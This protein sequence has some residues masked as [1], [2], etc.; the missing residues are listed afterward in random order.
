M[1]AS[2]LIINGKRYTK[3]SGP[4][5]F[6]VM[7]P[8]LDEY[9]SWNM[10]NI[11]LP[12]FMFLGDY[13][14]S[15]DTMCDTDSNTI[16]IT[17]QDWYSLLDSFSTDQRR[18]QYYIE[19]YLGKPRVDTFKTQPIRWVT[20]NFFECI[21]NRNT[22]PTTNIEWKSSEIRYQASD[23]CIECSLNFILINTYM[24]LK[25]KCNDIQQYITDIKSAISDT[26]IEIINSVLDGDWNSFLDKLFE[27]NRLNSILCEAVSKNAELNDLEWWKNQIKT[28][29]ELEV[30]EY[31][32]LSKTISLHYQGCKKTINF[33]KKII[34]NEPVEF[35]DELFSEE[36]H[37]L[38]FIVDFFVPIIDF[39]TL[40]SVFATKP[41]LVIYNAGN[42]HIKLLTE[43]L[44]KHF[45]LT[46]SSRPGSVY[47][48][49]FPKI[50]SKTIQGI[51]QKCINIKYTIDLNKIL[52]IYTNVH[53]G[54]N[55]MKKV[56][57][58]YSSVNLNEEISKIKSQHTVL[59]QY[60]KNK[61]HS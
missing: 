20:Q 50:W 56:L 59:S 44:S 36:N 28:V 48:D 21:S 25:D 31:S 15:I 19:T 16:S 27:H 54:A 60:I 33:I 26:P 9:Y 6:V 57:T 43:Y 47:V 30:D 29:Y 24:L 3:I 40:M 1:S 32:K 58:G 45:T 14:D 17:S 11:K 2:G 37:L 35:D 8:K 23:S 51:P 12:V 61:L 4:V 22:C 55:E 49:K 52:D 5:G 42:K 41:S 46:T 38:G 18:V 34:E 53:S 7:Y 13:H 10:K 39:Y